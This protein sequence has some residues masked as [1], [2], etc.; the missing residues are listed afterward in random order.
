MPRVVGASGTVAP[1]T[2]L[3][4]EASAVVPYSLPSADE[5]KALAALNFDSAS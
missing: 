2:K 3:A 4:A 1:T 5:L